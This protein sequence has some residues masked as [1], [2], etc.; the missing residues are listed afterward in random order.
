[1]S[2]RKVTS[3]DVINTTKKKKKKTGE[4]AKGKNIEYDDQLRLVQVVEKQGKNWKKVANKDYGKFRTYYNNAKK[5]Y[6]DKGF[7]SEKPYQNISQR[8]WRPEAKNQAEIKWTEEENTRE[9]G[10]TEIRKIIKRIE[11]RELL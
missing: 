1:M 10:H 7:H 5:K 3:E 11:N 2:K 8:I 4:R 6:Y 9:K